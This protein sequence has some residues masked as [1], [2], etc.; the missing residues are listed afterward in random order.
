[1]QQGTKPPSGLS[2]SLVQLTSRTRVRP[3]V[4]SQGNGTMKEY[5]LF[6]LIRQENKVEDRT[7]QIEFLGRIEKG[8]DIKLVFAGCKNTTATD[9]G[10][11][12]AVHKAF[13]NS[14]IVPA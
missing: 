7:F 6:R 5:R 8:F 2:A 13:V 10:A 12:T 4:D 11:R 3:R 1:M 9:T 14:R